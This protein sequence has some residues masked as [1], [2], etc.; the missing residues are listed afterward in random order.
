MAGEKATTHQG[1][2]LCGAVRYSIQGAPE[3]AAHC[4]CR[5]C[6]KA[7]GAGFAS[8][9]A[10]KSDRF[11]VIK[12]QIKQCETSPGI[13]RGFC[14]NCGTSLTY[15]AASVVDGQDWSDQAWFSA[16]SLDDPAIVTPTAHVYVS[17]QQPWVRLDD[18]LPVHQ[19]F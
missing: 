9:C 1:G 17:H 15:A 14:G 19:E 10:V 7:L 3:W 18:G 8:W 5:S 4:H 16:A 2:C 6:Q 11:A 12:G 13:H